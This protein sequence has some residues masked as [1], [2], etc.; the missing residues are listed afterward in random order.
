MLV[1]E[2]GVS[3]TVRSTTPRT[4]DFFSRYEDSQALADMAVQMLDAIAASMS[5]FTAAE[6]HKRQTSEV[7]EYMKGL[8]SRLT[9][10]VQRESKQVLDKTGTLIV[11]QGESLRQEMQR[12]EVKV[13]RIGGTVQQQMMNLIT[14]VDNTVRSSIAQLNIDSMATAVSESVRAW[15]GES[16][17]KLHDNQRKLKTSIGELDARLREEMRM[18]VSDPLQARHEALVL[19]LNSLPSK[20][21]SLCAAASEKQER[22]ANK[23]LCEGVADLHKLLRE[24]LHQQD[25]GIVSTH[26]SLDAMMKKVDHM[27]GEVGRQWLESK[28]RSADQKS[29]MVG[30]LMQVPTIV[31]GV[32]LESMQELEKQSSR[33]ASAVGG[34]QQQLVKIER[35][36]ADSMGSLCVLRKVSDDMVGKVDGLSS[37]V[38]AQHVRNTSNQRTKGQTGEQRLVDMLSDKLTQRDGY[39]VELVSGQAHSCDIV[40]KR[41]NCPDIRIECKNHGE[42]TN[43]KVRAKE[44]SRFQNDLLG[45]NTHGIFVSLHAGI[46]GKGEVELEQL[47]NGNFA[48]YLSN[49]QYDVGIISDMVALL[50]RLDKIIRQRE[51]GDEGQGVVIKVSAESMQRARLYLQDF[52]SKV[53]KTKTHLK[54]SIALL[55]EITFDMVERI[56]LGQGPGQDQ[57]RVTVSVAQE[58]QSLS[59]ESSDANVCGEC[60]LVCKSAQGLDRHKVAKHAIR[61]ESSSSSA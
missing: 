34:A 61:Q 14:S 2:P 47:A 36:L 38:L 55:N 52:G 5:Q 39:D 49:N 11:A 57:G 48:V 32:M 7:I 35:D 3:V 20:V 26:E 29:T 40:V 42:Q 44:V 43:E 56:L 25:I 28:D 24:G 58:Q 51:S 8:E 10:N 16:V 17:S 22:D 45:L 46:V 27:V 18:R 53:S 23:R 19:L 60:G 30:H 9:G 4:V 37:Q 59:G 21:S 12:V 54:E 33:L 31:R 1:I 50:Y 6:D 13:E 41:L 15:L